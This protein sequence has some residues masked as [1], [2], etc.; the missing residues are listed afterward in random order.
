MMKKTGLLSFLFLLL[1]I[2]LSACHRT[3]PGIESPSSRIDASASL[4]GGM[5]APK[6]PTFSPTDPPI[7]PAVSKVLSA[8]P[9]PSDIR[10]EAG[11]PSEP[12]SA[13]EPEPELESESKP[14]S[15]A[16][17]N[18]K[19]YILMYHHFV[20]GDGTDCDAW[21]LPVRQF[22]ND[23]QWLSDHGYTTVLPSQLAQGEPLP[24]RAVMI[25]MDDGYASNYLLAY[26][27]L[28]EF[29]AKAVIS[30]ITESVDDSS[31]SYYLSWEMC[32]EMANSGLVEF[33]SHTSR[34][35]LENNC[36]IA[37]L[38]DE[39]REAYEARVFPD[40]EASI[41]LIQSNLGT[42]VLFFAYPGGQVDRWADDFIKEHF[43]V[44]VTTKH[45]PAN[46][47]KGLYK[48][49]RHNI[50]IFEDVPKFLPA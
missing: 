28:Q 35:H 15:P 38:P 37:R 12:E 16:K 6:P 8:V 30:L 1:L 39:G 22:R 46:I 2:S 45:G 49:P 3:Q 9:A 11:Q 21:S 32:R 50:S 29:N 44:T 34:L 17:K 4:S 33:G 19:L 48:L 41:E 26:P 36:N 23:L 25:T 5:P 20:E 18:T 13:L 47:S 43:S 27:A 10:P 24:E 14:D 42:D 7:L 31:N 40:L